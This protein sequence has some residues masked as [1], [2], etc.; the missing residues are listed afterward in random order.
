MAKTF[1]F[2]SSF[3]FLASSAS[4]SQPTII[5]EEQIARLKQKSLLS[6]EHNI[7]MEIA[8]LLANAIQ[9]CCDWTFR[10]TFSFFN[11]T[12][13]PISPLSSPVPLLPP[14]PTLFFSYCF[15]TAKHFYC[16]KLAYYFKPCVATTTLLH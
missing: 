13:S 3:P 4:S 9:V 6:R 11:R 5:E 8:Q 1:K 12:L 7:D 14:L 2:I 15:H 16:F 10:N